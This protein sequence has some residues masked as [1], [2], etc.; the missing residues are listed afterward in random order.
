MCDSSWDILKVH[1]DFTIFSENNVQVG[2]NDK[3]I[4]DLSG[5]DSDFER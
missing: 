5:E 1:E 3:M 2:S 4:S